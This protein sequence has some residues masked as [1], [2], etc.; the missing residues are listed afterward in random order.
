MSLL[1]CLLNTV[2]LTCA[3]PVIS[4]W[5]SEFYDHIE[6]WSGEYQEVNVSPE[7]YKT[8]DLR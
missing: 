4:W 6:P 7:I 5:F 2:S 8:M 3:K 1:V